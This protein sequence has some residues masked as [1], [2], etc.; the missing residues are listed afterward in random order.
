MK[1]PPYSPRK[2][3]I[4]IVPMIDTIFFLLVYFIMATLTVDKLH[5]E[6]VGLPSSTTATAVHL[7]DKIVVTADSRG[8]CFIDQNEVPIS[9]LESSLAERLATSPSSTV[10]INCDKRVSV[11]RFGAIY[12]LVKQAN[13]RAVMVATTPDADWVGK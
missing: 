11:S 4:E 12:D 10:V 3:R 6:R 1:L 8:R 5:A 7:S 13:A 2:A 9:R